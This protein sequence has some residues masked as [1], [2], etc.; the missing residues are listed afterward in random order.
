MLLNFKRKH[1]EENIKLLNVQL[2]T[3]PQEMT[4][5]KS[6]KHSYKEV[7][8]APEVSIMS[9]LMTKSVLDQNHDN[10]DYDSGEESDHDGLLDELDDEDQ[11]D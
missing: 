10:I 9:K 1:N 5:Q 11:G 7:F 2:G 6:K 8:M 3:S 4:D